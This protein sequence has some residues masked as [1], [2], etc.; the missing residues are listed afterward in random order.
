[1]I[2][3]LGLTSALLMVLAP[4]PLKP[5]SSST[6]FAADQSNGL[7]VIFDTRVP[8]RSGAWRYIYIHQSATTEGNALM[9]ASPK[10]LHD[11]F[12][13]GNGQGAIDGEIQIGQLWN[14]QQSAL[15]PAGARAIDPGAISIVLV[16]DFEHASPTSMQMRRLTQL[17]SAL[18]A[19][20]RIPAESVTWVGP[21]GGAAGLGRYFPADAL[22]SQLLP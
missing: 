5:D 18:Q 17:I 4:A 16:G 1:M 8:A 19:R 13:I 15:P 12:V 6:L 9:L 11:H 20:F 22:R 21:A 10:G 2:G 3:C 7:E 14:H